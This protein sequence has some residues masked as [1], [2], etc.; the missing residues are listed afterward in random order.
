DN[1]PFLAFTHSADLVN[2]DVPTG[3]GDVAFVLAMATQDRNQVSGDFGDDR[4]CTQTNQCN[5]SAG[6]QCISF[7][8]DDQVAPPIVAQRCAV[9]SLPDSPVAPLLPIQGKQTIVVA[10]QDS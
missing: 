6:E 7:P 5:G 3:S 2:F 10:L 1:D 4:A 8:V 9:A